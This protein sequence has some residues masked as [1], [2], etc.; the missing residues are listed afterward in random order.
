MLN[1]DKIKDFA[2]KYGVYDVQIKQSYESDASVSM[3]L[4]LR[5]FEQL[6]GD[7]NEVKAQ[8]VPTI[9]SMVIRPDEAI[10]LKYEMNVLS[11]EELNQIVK[12]V[13]EAFH[14]NPLI[15]LPNDISIMTMSVEELERIKNY[16]GDLILCSD[17]DGIVK[18]Q[19]QI[20]GAR[21]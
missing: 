9:K 2:S 16:I 7:A 15:A 19:K 3:E 12:N 8:D 6:I 4:P 13:K 11:Y 20:S 1:S 5:R 17:F 21:S 18:A 10:V 14:K